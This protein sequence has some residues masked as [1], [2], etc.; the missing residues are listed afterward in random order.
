MFPTISSSLLWFSTFPL[1]RGS[2]VMAHSALARY[3]FRIWFL[4][5]FCT[6]SQP[7]LCLQPCAETT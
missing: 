3:I 5:A 1:L 4:S 2:T 7:L 6:S